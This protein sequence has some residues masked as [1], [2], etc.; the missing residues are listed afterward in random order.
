MNLAAASSTE[1][2]TK[3]VTGKRDLILVMGAGGTDEYET[4]FRE[5]ESKWRAVCKA[6]G[7]G[8]R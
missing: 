5:L 2:E 7:V 1:N 3:A 4:E 6:A 8:Y